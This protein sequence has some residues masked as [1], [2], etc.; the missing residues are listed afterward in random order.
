MIEIRACRDVRIGDITIREAAGWTL[1]AH[2]CDRLWLRGVVVQNDPF[3]PNN[4][5]FDLNGCRDVFIS[6]CLIATN[7]DAIVLK[8][9]RDARSCERVVIQN[10]ILRTHCA[11][12]KCGTESWHDFRH[13]TVANCVVHRSKPRRGL[14]RLRR[15]HHRTPGRY[16]P[17]GR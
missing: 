17:H 13:I 4:D 12:I 11:A 15:R 5:G 2:T 3:G 14:L 10:C 9:S 6:D 7:D 8:T 1:H 16:Q